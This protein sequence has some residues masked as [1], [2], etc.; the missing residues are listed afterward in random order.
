[1][2]FIMIKQQL[3]TCIKAKFDV[4]ENKVLKQNGS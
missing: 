3:I 2:E 1:M 4:D